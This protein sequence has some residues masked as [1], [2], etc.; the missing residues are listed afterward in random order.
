MAIVV[1]EAAS[2]II[3]T[4]TTDA[5]EVITLRARFVQSIYWYKPTTLAHLLSITDG[6]GR[7]V[8]KACVAVVDEGIIIPIQVVYDSLYCDDMDSGTL[9][10]YH[11]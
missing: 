2:P 4:G 9:Y 3:V 11:R 1:D 7:T 6:N 5:S 10:I 8:A